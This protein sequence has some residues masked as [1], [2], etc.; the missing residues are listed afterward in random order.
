MYNN[1]YQS[2]K[3]KELYSIQEEQIPV[4]ASLI[5]QSPKLGKQS[6][7]NSWND[8]VSSAVQAI[9]DYNPYTPLV[10][11]GAE[12]LAVDAVA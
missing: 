9:A 11:E 5:E 6:V 10:Q 2:E 4:L 7:Q 3:Y 1:P 12:V 8:A